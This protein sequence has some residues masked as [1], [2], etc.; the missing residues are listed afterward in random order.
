MY[1]IVA[2][3]KQL[4]LKVDGFT[5]RLITKQDVPF[6]VDKF[7]QK[8]MNEYMNERFDNLQDYTGIQMRLRH[9]AL[10]YKVNSKIDGEARLILVDNINSIIGGITLYERANEIIELGYWI[11]PSY[12]EKGLGTKLVLCTIDIIKKLNNISSIRLTI[13][14]DNIKSIGLALKI[15]FTQIDKYKGKQGYNLIYSMEI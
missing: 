9:L 15:G 14:E 5:L 1:N 8:F 10:S 3:N 6:Y 4:P 12:Q 7:K 2:L 13:R 11:T